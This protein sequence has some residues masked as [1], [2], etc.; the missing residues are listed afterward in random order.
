[1]DEQLNSQLKCDG[2]RMMAVSGLLRYVMYLARREP[3]QEN[4]SGNKV[5]VLLFLNL[6]ECRCM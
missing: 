3:I 5:L 1:M 4:K 2:Y 6:A